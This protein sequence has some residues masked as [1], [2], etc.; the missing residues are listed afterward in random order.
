MLSLQCASCLEPTV[1]GE[2]HDCSE[3]IAALRAEVEKWKEYGTSEHNA[4]TRIQT[5][6]DAACDWIAVR[7]AKKS[8]GLRRMAKEGKQDGAAL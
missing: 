6:L 4:A 1:S 8:N 2:H 5:A 3:I 7:D